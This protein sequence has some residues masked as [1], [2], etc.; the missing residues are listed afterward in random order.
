MYITPCI[1]IIHELFAVFAMS[2]S[3]VTLR[4]EIYMYL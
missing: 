1:I 3:V 2:R 4:S